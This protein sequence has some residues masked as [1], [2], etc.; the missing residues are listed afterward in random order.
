MRNRERQLW[1]EYVRRL[2]ERKDKKPRRPRAKKKPEASQAERDAVL[3]D[4]TGMAP[5][6]KARGLTK[7]RD[8]TAV[9]NLWITPQAEKL[10]TAAAPDRRKKRGSMVVL[11]R[12]F[13]R[14]L[15]S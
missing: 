4:L 3:D 6:P 1:T 5:A 8:V 10:S 11:W 15:S 14:P 2:E 12:R 13:C 7:L 9:D